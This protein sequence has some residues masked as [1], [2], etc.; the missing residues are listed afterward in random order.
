MTLQQNVHQCTWRITS[1]ALD[2]NTRLYIWWVRCTWYHMYHIVLVC[3]WYFLL[4][5]SSSSRLPLLPQVS[6]QPGTVHASRIYCIRLHR[7]ITTHF[8]QFMYQ[9]PGTRYH[10]V[11]KYKKRLYLIFMFKMCLYLWTDRYQVVYFLRR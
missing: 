1:S 5:S 8:D 11:H 3:A 4:Y 7:R 2:G 6:Y 10:S 9:A